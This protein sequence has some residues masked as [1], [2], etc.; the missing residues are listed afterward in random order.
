MSFGLPARVKHTSTTTGTGTL[1]LI[2]PASNMQAFSAVFGAGPVKVMYAIAGASYWEIGVGTYTGGGTK[3]LSRDT[4]FAS[5]AGGAN[6]SLPVATHDVIAWWPGGYPSAVIAGSTTL[7]PTDLFQTLVYTGGA[8]TL[9]LP[10]VANLPAGMLFPFV[11][12]GSG[13]WTW[14]PNGAELINGGATAVIK[15]GQA[16]WAL[17]QGPTSAQWR[18]LVAPVANPAALDQ[19]QTFLAAQTI[20]IAGLN[21]LALSSSD[22]GASAGPVLDAFRDS[23]SPAVN[24]LIASWQASG[25]S[26]TNVKRIYAEILAQILDP[27]NASEDS[28]VALRTMVAGTL[29]ARLNI[30][31]GVYT[32]NAT[33]GDPGVDKINAKDFQIDGASLPIKKVFTS[34]NQTITAAG[35]LTLAHGLAVVPVFVTLELE[36]TSADAGYSVGN[37]IE[38][39]IIASVLTPS[40]PNLGVS[41]KKDATNLTVRFGSNGPTFLYSNAT[42]GNSVLLTN[43]NWVARFKAYA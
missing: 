23:A 27:T 39:A 24:D 3:T 28:L 40:T 4:I 22:A 16:G 37:I 1:A 26:S 7:T 42:S 38:M 6:V 43:A 12:A 14:D 10:A 9:N 13:D 21:P 29:A 41:V 5:S 15:P 18:L 30:V 17:L 32:P 2:D 11:H 36:C 20:S 35:A 33:G 34:T 31:Q 8:G 19:I 25:R